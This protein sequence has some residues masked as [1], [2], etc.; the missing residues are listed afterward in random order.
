MCLSDFMWC[1]CFQLCVNKI[2]ELEFVLENIRKTWYWCLCNC[3][4][5]L[6]NLPCILGFSRMILRTF[7]VVAERWRKG[8]FQTRPHCHLLPPEMPMDRAEASEN[9]CIGFQTLLTKAFICEWFANRSN[10]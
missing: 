4:C 7:S 9:R 5:C 1:V 10:N 3:A 2:M 8:H 6:C